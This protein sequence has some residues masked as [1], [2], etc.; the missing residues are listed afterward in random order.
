MR[1]LI[2]SSTAVALHKQFGVV[3]FKQFRV[4]QNIKAT[5]MESFFLLQEE[6]FLGRLGR[7]KFERKN[8]V[9]RE[10]ETSEG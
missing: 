8:Q 2:I 10:C 4:R 3:F 6:C 1:I 7:A 9:F 5:E